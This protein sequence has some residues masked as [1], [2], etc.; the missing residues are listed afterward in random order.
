MCSL[1]WMRWRK[2][3]KPDR[4]ACSKTSTMQTPSTSQRWKRSIVKRSTTPTCANG[5]RAEAE[6]TALRARQPEIAALS[7]QVRAADQA[8]S[9]ADKETRA[10]EERRLLHQ[11]EE[12]LALAR[13]QAQKAA[14]QLNAA[15]Q[16]LAQAEQQKQHADLA[17]TRCQN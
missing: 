4:S 15:A 16:H 12:T 8:R 11:Q 10:A 17:T 3:T 5:S 1:R 7:G 9:L 14:Q 2:Q 6:L 13:Q